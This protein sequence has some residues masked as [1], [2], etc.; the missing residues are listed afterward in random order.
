MRLKLYLQAKWM[1]LWFRGRARQDSRR[2]RD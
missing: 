1:P 2:V